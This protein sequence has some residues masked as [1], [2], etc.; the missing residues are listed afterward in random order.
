MQHPPG[1]RVLQLMRA[2]EA[3]RT[4]AAVDGVHLAAP[5]GVV[6]GLGAVGDAIVQRQHR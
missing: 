6:G 5:V 3:D 2:A 1:H 4:G